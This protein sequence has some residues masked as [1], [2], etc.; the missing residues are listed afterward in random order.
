M[1]F[2]RIGIRPGMLWRRT[3]QIAAGCLAVARFAA[4]YKARA[5]SWSRRHDPSWKEDLRDLEV[6]SGVR[7]R[8]TIVPGLRK[9]SLFP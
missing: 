7:R 3:S 4:T 1:A 2:D 5:S 6:E 8:A 9:I